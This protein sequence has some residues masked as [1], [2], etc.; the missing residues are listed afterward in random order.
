M[1]VPRIRALQSKL[2]LEAVLARAIAYVGNG[3][4]GLMVDLPTGCEMNLETFMQRFRNSEGNVP[5]FVAVDDAVPVSEKWLQR[6]GVNAII[7]TN[8]LLGAAHRAMAEAGMEILSSEGVL[9]GALTRRKTIGPPIA[10]DSV[11]R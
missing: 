5:I 2:E 4:D 9:A 10:I 7:Y 1:I 8:Q 11:E 6:I 3:A